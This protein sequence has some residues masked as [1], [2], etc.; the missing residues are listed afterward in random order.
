MRTCALLTASALTL[1]ALPALPLPADGAVFHSRES[2]L[3]VAFPGADRITPK[4][5]IL[6]PEDAERIRELA[7]VRPESRL[8]TAYTGYSGQE[9][10]GWAF[11]DT[12]NVRTL[13]ETILLVVGVDGRVTGTHLLAFHEPSEYQPPEGWLGRFTGTALDRERGVG[14]VDSISGSTLSA[15]AVTS[16]V[17]R[18]LA[19][20]QVRL[21]PADS[22][23]LA[24]ERSP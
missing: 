12:H 3:R 8:V 23:A 20:W 6:S 1:L 2:A 4:D 11:I 17:R 21:A 18:L 5:L 7:G 15:Q 24:T 13:P 14:T 10:L 9:L 16:T 19:V 22:A